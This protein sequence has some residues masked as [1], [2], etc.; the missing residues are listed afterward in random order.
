MSQK[1]MGYPPTNIAHNQ[2]NMKYYQKIN[3]KTNIY[4]KYNH[5]CLSY[6]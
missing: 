5:E 2:E 1:I 3:L 6:I 4:H